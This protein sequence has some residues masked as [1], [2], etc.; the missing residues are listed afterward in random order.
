MK[1]LPRYSC[2][3]CMALLNLCKAKHDILDIGVGTKDYKHIHYVPI[4]TDKPEGNTFWV[5][6]C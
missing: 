1:S 5:N 6:L 2:N 3:P 4:H